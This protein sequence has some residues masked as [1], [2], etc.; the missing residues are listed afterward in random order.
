M[1]NITHLI[2]LFVFTSSSGFA[3][4]KPV[5]YVNPFVGT[6][7]HGHTFP[8]AVLPFGMVQLS[9]DTRVDGSW[10]GCS[11]YHHSDT[12]V[13]GFSHTH[14]SGTGCSDWGDIL[15]MP[16]P[17]IPPSDNKSYASGFSHSTEK[18]SPGFYEVQLK[19]GNIKVELTVTPR[20]GIH[21]YTF[22]KSGEYGLVVDLAH[23]DKTLEASIRVRDSVTVVGHRTSE[24]WAKKQHIYFAM[25]FSKPVKV[26]KGIN[27]K[28]QTKDNNY[29]GDPRGM[30]FTYNA[31]AGESILVKVG[32]SSVSMRGALNNL[33][34]EA[35]HW[36]FETYKKEA[37]EIWNKQLSKI[38][39]ESRDAEKLNV[40]YTSLYHC[41]I[42]PSLNMDVDKQYRGRDEKIHTAESFTNYSV[43]SLWDTYRALHPLFSIIERKRSSDFINSFLV[44][45]QQAGRLP[46]WELSSN[47]TDC[48]IGFH[49]VSVIADAMVKGIRGF[50]TL[51]V[52]NAMKAAASYTGFGIPQ[53]NKQGYL[54]I[55]DQSESVSKS[56]E[57]A[58]DNWCVAQVAGLLKEEGDKKMFLKRSLA[59][60]NLFDVTTGNMRPRKNGGWLSPFL[61][62]EINNHF[63]E[64]NSWQYSFYVPHD[65]TGL[66]KLHGSE[67]KFEAK[68]DELFQTKQK[69]AGRE[70]AD[71]T[72]LIGQYAH[73][74]E[75]SHH[76]AYLYNYVGKPQK[77]IDRVKWI[78]N[79][80]YKN[81]TD[82][83]IGNEDCG[84]MSAWYV[85]SAMGMYPVC[86]GSTQY[87]L[88]EPIFNSAKVNL[89]NGKTF[90]IKAN[91]DANKAVTAISVNGTKKM[92]SFINFSTILSGAELQFYNEDLSTGSNNFGVAA[93]NRPTSQVSE[94]SVI[95]APLI[96]SGKRVFKD[97]TQVSISM[98]NLP[99]QLISVYTMDGKDPD[100][101]AKVYTKMI[102]VD[103]T[104]VIKARI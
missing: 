63:T 81:S 45:Y 51:A 38:E 98:I 50:D 15:L 7:G 27:S 96:S 44:Q 2:L 28:E 89:E 58:Y 65:L 3:Q 9:P 91:P 76:M 31:E 61:P 42:H 49:S 21:R 69:T 87:V 62:N 41:C 19:K 30:T 46:V 10:D 95:P 84:Q 92:E 34:A 66:I 103:S 74:N 77:T 29:K 82:G 56:L 73:G 22:S 18:A 64:G 70:Q 88:S 99:V 83:L 26:M 24:A 72:G 43:F 20:V 16:T 4:K 17:G 6:G 37:E 36:E 39:V 13:Y 102:T 1:K 32:I 71:V 48:M 67:A 85:L 54:Q 57:Y 93:T 78:C 80:F 52:Y 68:L 97:T 90:S 101:L 59:Y 60:Y 75:P 14:L 55:D 104:G 25:R 11:G 5:A 33:E 35:K 23:R 53:F 40:F 79:N 8:G 100:A 12:I 47:E 86:P 94:V